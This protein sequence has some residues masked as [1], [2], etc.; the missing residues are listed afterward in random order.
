[1]RRHGSVLTPLLITFSVFA[2]LIGAV[3]VVNY[4]AVGRQ[5][6][7]AQQVTGRYTVL[8]QEESAL[9]AAFG[10][11]DFAVLF[12]NVT[13]VRSYLLPL[14]PARSAFD[15]N[16]AA[17]RSHATPGL[18]G[19]IAA[20]ARTGA[21]WFALAPKLVAI[22]RRTAAAKI[23]FGRS[24]GLGTAFLGAT[25]AI[26]GRL[27]DDIER[28]TTSSKQALRTSLVWSAVA[29]GVALLL[30]LAS[31]LSTVYTVTRPLRALT[32]TVGR[33]TQGDHAAR[34]VVAGS[35]EVRE[36]AQTV[37]AQADEADRLRA[38]EA[39][40][41]RLRAAAREAGLRIREPLVEEEVLREARHALEQTVSADRVSLR[42]IEEDRLT[43]PARADPG[44]GVEDDINPRLT[45]DMLAG[46]RRL[47][48]AQGSTVIQ[49][50]QG[51]DGSQITPGLR[52]AVRGIGV[53]SLIVTPFGVGSTLL[54]MLVAQR[55][56][57]GRPWTPAE[58]D[59]VES[60][61]ADLGRGLNHA[62]QYERRTGWWRTSGRSTRPS[63]TSSP[64]FPMNCAPR[65]PPSRV[66]SRCSARTRLT[67]WTMSSA[68]WW[69]P[70]TAARTGCGT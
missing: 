8:Q 40:S 43:P 39:E 66:M 70:S 36:V 58:V 28:L 68:A 18:R 69:K 49:D 41:H 9:E 26:Q 31:S 34:A 21:T 5:S 16:L 2:V 3:M 14:G 54:G 7:V 23:L 6:A 17:L 15:R 37:N 51:E 48:H 27:H 13:G 25:T 60:I 19:L 46:L 63:R 10:T 53:A 35:P 50:V 24:G 32:A 38:Q 55:L 47:F 61:A 1:M 20:Q 65:S 57:P 56:T 44:P 29:L 12:Y 45:D 4:V 67:G 52:E 33:L 42:L 11:A 30:V 64:R 22:E 59:A 62:R